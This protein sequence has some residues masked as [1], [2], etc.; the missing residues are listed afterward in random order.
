MTK[1]RLFFFV[2][3]IPLWYVI[4]KSTYVVDDSNRYVSFKNQADNTPLTQQSRPEETSLFKNL[5]TGS[6]TRD[7][8]AYVTTTQNNSHLVSSGV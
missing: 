6:N 2:K 3:L 4:I 5:T 1:T 8:T 7:T